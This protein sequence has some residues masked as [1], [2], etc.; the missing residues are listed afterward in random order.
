MPLNVL[1]LIGLLT[2]CACGDSEKAPPTAVS[3]ETLD[4]I[5]GRPV[6]P[7][8][9]DPLPMQGDSKSPMPAATPTATA[10]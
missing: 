3:T 7:V 6:D 8:T 1:I 10:T 5:T 9:G 4:P 2:L